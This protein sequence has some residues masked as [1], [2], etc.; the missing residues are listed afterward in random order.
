[1]KKFKVVRSPDSY[2]IYKCRLWTIHDE[3]GIWAGKYHKEIWPVYATK[4]N[5]LDALEKLIK[6]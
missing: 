4:K 2:A 3:N 5:A 1:M 6:N